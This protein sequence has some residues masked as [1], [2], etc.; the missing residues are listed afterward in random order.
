[1]HRKLAEP[2]LE[3]LLKTSQSLYNYLQGSSANVTDHPSTAAIAKPDIELA[4]TI[5]LLNS[6]LQ[7]YVSSIN[8]RGFAK[9]ASPTDIA[10]LAFSLSD[11]KTSAPLQESKAANI[12][13]TPMSGFDL[14]FSNSMV[15]PPVKEEVL[16]SKLLKGMQQEYLQKIS[17]LRAEFNSTLAARE[18]AYKKDL[19]KLRVIIMRSF[20]IP[21]EF[22]GAALE[23]VDEAMFDETG[24]L[25]WAAF[26][27]WRS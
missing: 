18:D 22:M 1:M 3:A 27:L 6:C 25:F 8:G 4:D 9:L 23:G 19:L 24:I 5:N 26:T 16:V 15:K 21:D 12:Q 13:N 20:Q 14:D 2:L 11:S 10:P 17:D 7:Q